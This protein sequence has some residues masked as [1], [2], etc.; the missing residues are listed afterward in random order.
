MTHKIYEEVHVRRGT[1]R[2]TPPRGGLLCLDEDV[3]I[4]RTQHEFTDKF[5]SDGDGSAV[6][7]TEVRQIV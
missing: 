7:H 1:F 6:G 4:A 2:Q 5:L 3:R